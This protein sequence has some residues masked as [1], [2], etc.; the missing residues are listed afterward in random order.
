[1]LFEMIQSV[2]LVYALVLVL[3]HLRFRAGS[4][5]V[6][7]ISSLSA[8]QGQGHLQRLLGQLPP[9]RRMDSP[10]EKRHMTMMDYCLIGDSIVLAIPALLP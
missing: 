6:V 7:K 8:C 3:G 2:A 1:M 10:V 5:V 4:F 9:E